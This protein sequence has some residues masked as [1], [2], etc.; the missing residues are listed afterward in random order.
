M[1]ER[2]YASEPGLAEG[3]LT[4]L[5]SALV[6]RRH[7]ATLADG[8]GLEPL[9]RTGKGLAGAQRATGR[10]GRVPRSVLSNAMEAVI[11][12][13]YLDGGWDA[14]RA[15][16]NRLLDDAENAPPLPQPPPGSPSPLPGAPA[17]PEVTG[18]VNYKSRLQHLTQ[19]AGQG[20]PHYELLEASG[21]DHA[22]TFTVRAVIAGTRHPP[23]SGRTIKA[24]EQ[25]AAAAALGG[26]G[27]M[28]DAAVVFHAFTTVPE[29]LQPP[30]RP[31]GVDHQRGVP[32]DGLVVHRVVVGGD[33]NA[34]L[35]R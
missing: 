25:A 5:K 4:K 14:A 22:R 16:V 32:H 6:S 35:G 29:G 30:R 20:P 12:G 15:C 27:G 18:G 28:P 26:A 13:V 9:I 8:L 10:P 17:V 34:V 1:C 33:Q 31:A 24:A 7:C 2:L 11:A 21:P 19:S 3:D 23:G